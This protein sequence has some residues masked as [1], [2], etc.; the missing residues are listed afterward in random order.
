MIPQERGSKRGFKGLPISINLC[1]FIL[2]FIS[3]ELSKDALNDVRV[4]GG[5]SILN[6]L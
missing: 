1:H 5:K 3:L 6:N 2:M 4:I